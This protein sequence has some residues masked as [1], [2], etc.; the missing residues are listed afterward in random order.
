MR[1]QA[2]TAE[3]RTIL[4]GKNTVSRHSDIPFLLP[5]RLIAFLRHILHRELWHLMSLQWISSKRAAPPAMLWKVRQNPHNHSKQSRKRSAY[6]IVRINQNWRFIRVR[7]AGETPR[8]YVKIKISLWLFIDLNLPPYPLLSS[9]YQT[10]IVNYHVFL[11]MQDLFS[12]FV[13]ID[14]WLYRMFGC[15]VLSR[16]NLYD[17]SR[18]SQRI[19]AA[20][21]A[22]RWLTWMK[23]S[24]IAKLW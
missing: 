4:L 24:E 8:H 17:D 2:E 22:N 1:W 14:S 21:K 6:V 20:R 11:W 13:A 18:Q 5:F 12:L 16:Q 15:M 10:H 19:P 9:K 3:K 23:K 7:D